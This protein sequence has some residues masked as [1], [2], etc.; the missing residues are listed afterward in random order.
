MPSRKRTAYLE[1]YDRPGTESGWHFLTG[2][3]ASIAALCSAIGFRYTQDPQTKLYTHAAGRGRG[4]E[5]RGRF[6]LF[7][8]NRLSAQGARASSSSRRSAGRVGSPI[9]R[10]LLLC[11]DYD[12][13]T[14]KYTL[15]ILRLDPR[16]GH[17]DGR[18]A[19]GVSVRDVSPRN[20]WP[21]TGE[22]GR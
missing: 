6:A 20:A 14:G 21:P 11:Y 8:W 15:S 2:E 4:D 3:Q 17:G 5:R 10:L 12:R 18:F 13:A 19:H 22:Q 9:G 1:R 16:A 7:L